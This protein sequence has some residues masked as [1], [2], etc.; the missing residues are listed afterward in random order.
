MP[1]FLSMIRVDEEAA[2]TNAPDP[3]FGERMG[4]LFEEIK[5]GG[6]ITSLETQR[7]IKGGGVIDVWL[8]ITALVD[9][10]RVPGRGIHGD[11][12]VAAVDLA[13]DVKESDRL[14]HERQLVEPAAVS[15]LYRA[16]QRLVT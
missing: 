5:R 6:K 8:T 7:R 10:V 15:H 1:R 2:Q 11:T 16:G 4:A 14:G 13:D 12:E 9:D 3:E